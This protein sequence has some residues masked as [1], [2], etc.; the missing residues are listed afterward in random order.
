M[1]EPVWTIGALL[2]WTAEHFAKRGLDSP[3]LDAEVLL[4]HALGC[5]RI[6]LYTRSEEVANNDARMRFRSLVDQRLRGMPVAY[7]VGIKEF[8][9]LPFEVSPAVLIPRPATEI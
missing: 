8:F 7:L 9:L 3:R 5:R 4:A 1:P 6:E 2:R